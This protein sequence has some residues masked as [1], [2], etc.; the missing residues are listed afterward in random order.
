MSL[1]LHFYFYGT[2]FIFIACNDLNAQNDNPA[3]PVQSNELIRTSQSW[4]GVE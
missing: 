3:T 4:D 1:R 2:I